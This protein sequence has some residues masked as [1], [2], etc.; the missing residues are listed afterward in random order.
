MGS[1]PNNIIVSSLTIL[2]LPIDITDSSL[3]IISMPI[4]IMEQKFFVELASTSFPNI[5]SRN[6]SSN[7][8][9]WGEPVERQLPGRL[10]GGLKS[11]VLVLQQDN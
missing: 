1:L 9:I 4:N 6:W 2:S 10:R 11:V 5:D 7:D 3:T 8:Q